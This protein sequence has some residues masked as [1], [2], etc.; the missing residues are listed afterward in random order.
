MNAPKRLVAYLIVFVLLC[1]SICPIALASESGDNAVS[2]VVAQLT[3][4]DT[5]QEMQNKRSAYTA[6]GHYDITTTD[7]ARIA[8]HNAARTGYETYIDTMFAARIAAQNA[9]DALTPAQQAQVDPALVAK[10][11]D[12]LQTSFRTGTFSVTPTDDAY[13]FEAVNGGLGYAYEVSNHMV[14]GNIPQTFVLVDT[15]DGKTSWTPDGLYQYGKSNYDVVYCC[16]IKQGVA[17]TSDYKR[18]NLENSSYYSK[19]AAEH[20][21]AIVTNAYPYVTMEEMKA[22]LIAGGL[23]EAFVNTLTRADM[24]AAVQQAIWTYAN[25]DDNWD[26]VGYFAS[27]DVPKNEGS[28]FT[29]LHDYTNESWEWFPGA[30][31]RSYSP[32]AAY[33]VNNLAY[34]LCTLD[35]VAASGDS[36]LIS[37]V[38]ITR[39]N[40]I[41]KSNDT[42]ELGMYI[43]LNVGAGK[44]DSLSV[45]VESCG[46]DGSVTGK[47]TQT[48]YESSTYELSVNARYGDTITVTVEGTQDLGRGVYFYEP[49]GGRTE[50][51]CFVGV[52]DGSTRVHVEESFT[53]DKDIEM[54]IRI[55]KTAADTGLPLSDITFDVYHVVLGEGETIGEV[56]TEEELAKYATSENKV[57]SVT[58]DITGYA[59]LE[60]EKGLY[61]VVEQHNADKVKAPVSPFYISVPMPVERPNPDDS[62]DSE[63]VIEYRDVVSIYPKNEPVIPPDV[64]PYFPPP[65]GNVSGSFSIVKHDANDKSKTLGGAS[66]QVF[67]AATADDT[68]EQIISCGGTKYAVV[69]VTVNG[70]LLILTTDENGAAASPQLLCGTYFLVETE[71]PRGYDK[72][73]EAISVTVKSNLVSSAE[74]VYIA[75]NS[76]SILPETG[77][78]GTV[79]MIALGSILVIVAVIFWATEKK[80]RD[81]K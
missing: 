12:Q 67:R 38:N 79:W 52:S 37:D 75:N 24:M 41:D 47:T 18:L 43:H 34:Y 57:G 73:D 2:D 62:T 31:V 78:S 6:S 51:Q 63:I 58:T 14:S 55:Y 15:S 7:A 10:L 22:N 35:G 9:Y 72:L 69:P 81:Y 56:P 1:T 36:I 21:R 74:V 46:P 30:G 77:G 53:F 27:I 60:L 4:I 50:S 76:G 71:A 48:I 40:L 80:M 61:L 64:P 59:S 20:V 11:N 33:R 32:K 42:Y 23:D 3:S 17:Y 5:L 45:S 68:N 54:G 16:D 29:V 66:F 8:K 25:A 49:R 70:E 19:S 44:N 28:Y 39:A 65:P 26:N 13:T